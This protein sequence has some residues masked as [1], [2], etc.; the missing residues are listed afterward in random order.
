TIER[1]KEIGIMRA[2]GASRATVLKIFLLEALILGVIG[3]LVGSV[4]SVVAGYG[5]NYLVLKETRYVFQITT[6]GYILLG[7]SI[8][9]SVSILSGLYPAWKASRL[10]PIE[11][12]RFE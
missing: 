10:E 7:F 1:T 6:I 9:I 4:L 5:I 8:G 3:S 12:L 2:I 11:A